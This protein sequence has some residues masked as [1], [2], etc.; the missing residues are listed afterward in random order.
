MVRF[1]QFHRAFKARPTS[2]YY[3]IGS[4]VN[5]LGQSPLHAPSVFNFYSPNFTPAGPLATANLVGPEFEIT[6]ATSVAS[7]AN[8]SQW[9]I[10]AGWG[11]W[12]AGI[13]QHIAPDYADYLPLADTPTQMLDELDLVL[14]AACLD[15]GL[16][17]QIAQAVGKIFWNDNPSGQSQ[18][19]LYTA[20]WLIINSPDY[21]VQK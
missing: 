15:A 10:I 11:S 16:K 18:E 4:L 8:V 7:F 19:R 13:G 21:S 14:C 3:N 2:G 17:S 20:L 6:N 9:G 5:Q 1:V 12:R